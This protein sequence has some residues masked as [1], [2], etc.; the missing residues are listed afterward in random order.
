MHLQKRQPANYPAAAL[1]RLPPYAAALHRADAFRPRN[2]EEEPVNCTRD[3]GSL[4]RR[5]YTLP[6][7]RLTAL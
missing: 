5:P 1:P 6:S 4:P 7:T 3:A 2:R